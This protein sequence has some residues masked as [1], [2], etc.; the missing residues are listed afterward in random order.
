MICRARPVLEIEL[1][2]G[3][4][5]G[6][7]VT[8][9]PAEDIICIQRDPATK[10]RFEFDKVFPPQSSQE[11]VFAA[12]QPLCVSVLDGYNV[13]EFMLSSTAIDC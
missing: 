10:N 2:Q 9:F 8:E 7:D 4:G 3:G 1:K 12:V 5:A 13:K 11:E 6:V